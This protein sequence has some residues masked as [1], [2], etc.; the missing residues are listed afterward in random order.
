MYKYLY[1]SIIIIFTCFN[2]YA[3]DKYL[4]FDVD[5]I[6]TLHFKGN[7]FDIK[8]ISNDILIISNHNYI[9]GVKYTNDKIEK[10]MLF[11]IEKKNS[12]IT[13]SD[14]R[15]IGNTIDIAL[16]Y[17]T[18][19]ILIYEVVNSQI[20]LVS[21]LNVQDTLQENRDR[22]LIRFIKNIPSVLYTQKGNIIY[23]WNYKTSE[24]IKIHE[25]LG[26]KSISDE[27]TNT[28]ILLAGDIVIIDK[29]K[30]IVSFDE[31]I[32][33]IQKKENNIVE[34]D[35][36]ITFDFF[37]YSLEYKDGKIYA[38]CKESYSTDENITNHK[39]I[40]IDNK[41]NI[42]EMSWKDSYPFVE[43]ED[44][45]ILGN[46]M[47][48]I[49][50]F[51]QMRFINQQ[52]KLFF[53]SKD[54]KQGLIQSIYSYN[55]SIFTIDAF[56]LLC[57]WKLKDNLDSRISI[58]DIL[59]EIDNNSLSYKFVDLE[60]E[61]SQS[62]SDISVIDDILVNK[63]VKLLSN[64]K[65]IICEINGFTLNQGNIYQNKILS[66]ERAETIKRYFIEKLDDSF[67]NRITTVGHGVII[68]K[69]IVLVRFY[70]KI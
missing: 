10:K 16:R 59:D 29:N 5:L 37:P 28:E 15:L 33:I 56:G 55:N 20:K 45:S 49:T 25:E 53:K 31:K 2:S 35:S 1:L 27:Q 61:F 66:E 13:S 36:I 23:Q 21:S 63:I 54:T 44:I 34:I 46:D 58:E 68:N 51:N 41:N 67:K 48:I 43:S 26:L 60:V 14:C 7:H 11:K 38:L 32:K 64:R 42:E 4:N 40:I 30:F 18:G 39:I 52:K 12:N 62:T 70:I 8:G 50:P 65:D 47:V 22:K 24:N 19:E 9:T 17:S 6:D 3:Q 57:K 69:K